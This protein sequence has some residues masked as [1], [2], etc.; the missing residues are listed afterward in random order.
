VRKD[1]KTIPSSSFS[2]TDQNKEL[3]QPTFLPADVTN[4]KQIQDMLDKIKQQYG[5]L[6]VVLN[7]AGVGIA[8]RT[9]NINKVKTKKKKIYIYLYFIFSVRYMI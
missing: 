3:K 4:E 8:R 2:S 9:Y 7:C 6:D 5:R 1:N